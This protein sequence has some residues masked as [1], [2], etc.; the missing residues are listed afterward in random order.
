MAK[1]NGREML[2][3][4]WDGVSAYSVIAGIT[5]KSLAINNNL[6]D[7]ST[8]DA[9]TPANIIESESLAGIRSFSVSGDIT[10]EDDAAF[11]L[12]EA[13]ARANPPS[14]QFQITI[15]DYGTYT[16][17]WFIESLEYSGDMEGA[18]L[19]TISLK[20][21]GTITFATV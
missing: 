11:G 14:E 8:P 1:Q 12:A 3:A 4:V 2:L 18:V 21:S 17:T 7:V 5:A 13:A 20:A 10:F 9:A 16:G 15:P 6:I 19:A